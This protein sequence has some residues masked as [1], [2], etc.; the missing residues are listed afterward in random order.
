MVSD[1]DFNLYFSNSNEVSTFLYVYWPFESPLLFLEMPVHIFCLFI[2]WVLLFLL[3]SRRSLCILDINTD[4][5]TSV[6]K[7][8]PTCDL[9]LHS[10]YVSFDREVHHF[11]VVKFSLFLSRLHFF[12]SYLGTPFPLQCYKLNLSYC[13]GKVSSFCLKY[14]SP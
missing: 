12:L 4:S 8:L 3:I 14:L 9:S 5:V 6:A 1:F 11:K 13:L 7:Y 2:Y 10:L